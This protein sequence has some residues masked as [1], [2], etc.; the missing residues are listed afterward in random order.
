MS[1]NNNYSSINAARKHKNHTTK[2][3]WFPRPNRLEALRIAIFILVLVTS[4][5]ALALALHFLTVLQSNDLTHFVPFALFA[6]VASIIGMIALIAIV[7]VHKSKPAALKVELAIMGFLGILWLI[8]SIF[9]STSPAEN[10]DVQCF[11]DDGDLLDEDDGP[12]DSELFHAQYRALTAIGSVNAFSLLIMCAVL[13]YMALRHF[14]RTR[15][16][17]S[18]TRKPLLGEKKSSKQRDRSRSKSR[19]APP[20]TDLPQRVARK[21]TTKEKPISSGLPLPA[22]A[23]GASRDPPMSRTMAAATARPSQS[24]PPPKPTPP[25]PAPKRPPISKS[26]TN[27]LPSR[28]KPSTSKTANPVTPPPKAKVAAGVRSASAPKPVARGKTR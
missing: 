1:P 24:K 7:L 5:V 19:S 18:T 3:R 14:N 26:K 9:I 23:R 22:T 21:P 15:D 20:L 13:T 11:S 28:D 16:W 6:S 25:P 10:A 27:P 4:L 12:F 17:V 2:R 8:L